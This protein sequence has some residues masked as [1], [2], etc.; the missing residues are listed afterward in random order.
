[1]DVDEFRERMRELADKLSRT[2][3]LGDEH[4]A[5]I[6]IFTQLDDEGEQDSTRYRVVLL[7]RSFFHGVAGKPTASFNIDATVDSYE[8][9]QDLMGAHE[10]T[11][12]KYGFICTF[13]KP[14]DFETPPVR[15]SKWVTPNIL[16][17]AQATD[18]HL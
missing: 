2:K 7:W 5:S 6:S 12:D 11:L 15:Y 9:A 13:I 14:E 3:H 4:Q 8:E 18:T 1:M 10:T 16:Q 17:R